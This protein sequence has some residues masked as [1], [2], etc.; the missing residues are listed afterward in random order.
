MVIEATVKQ[1][2]RYL[3]RMLKGPI[4][5]PTG[6]SMLQTLENRGLVKCVGAAE[7]FR[8]VWAITPAGRAALADGGRD[9]G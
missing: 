2:R 4:T 5:V 7:G 6:N 3:E 8:S 1:R 9:E